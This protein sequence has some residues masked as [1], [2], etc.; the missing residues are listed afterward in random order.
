MR[1]CIQPHSLRCASPWSLWFS[2]FFSCLHASVSLPLTRLRVHASTCPLVQTRLCIS[3]LETLFICFRVS[4]GHPQGMQGRR[5]T[6]RNI[7]SYRLITGKTCHRDHKGQLGEISSWRAVARLARWRRTCEN[8]ET[9]V[10]ARA[11]VGLGMGNRHIHLPFP[12]P[13]HTELPWSYRRCTD[14]ALHTWR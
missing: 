7:G 2:P 11:K 1:L 10:N 13:L 8:L 6:C 3:P 9:C 14:T 4:S 5:R 12:H